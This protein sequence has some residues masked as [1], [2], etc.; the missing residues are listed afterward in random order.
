MK[1]ISQMLPVRT[2]RIRWF[3]QFPW[4]E[5]CLDWWGFDDLN[6]FSKKLYSW[7]PAILEC[8]DEL[9][10]PLLVPSYHSLGEASARQTDSFSAFQQFWAPSFIGFLLLTNKYKSN[11]KHQLFNDSDFYCIGDAMTSLSQYYINSSESACFYIQNDK[12]L[13]IG[14]HCESLVFSSYFPS[15]KSIFK[16]WNGQ[17]GLFSQFLPPSKNTVEFMKEVAYV[18]YHASY[19]MRLMILTFRADHHFMI[20]YQPD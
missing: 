16:I 7:V 9:F 14:Q 19:D 12:E 6:S 2:N 20:Y 3:D 8:F 11:I 4:F 10:F 17:S 13:Y 1:T 18:S 5:F 15:T